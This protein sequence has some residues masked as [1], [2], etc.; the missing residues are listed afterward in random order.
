MKKT[1]YIIT[2]ALILTLAIALPLFLMLLTSE[3]EG[4]KNFEYLSNSLELSKEINDES[5]LNDDIHYISE[6]NNNQYNQNILSDNEGYSFNNANDSL[7]PIYNKG[8][9]SGVSY[10]KSGK[11]NTIQYEGGRFSKTNFSLD[12]TWNHHEAN[13]I[14]SLGLEICLRNDFNDEWGVYDE[15]LYI[16]DGKSEYKYDLHKYLGINYSDVSNG[17]F[18]RDTYISDEYLH[19]NSYDVDNNGNVILSSRNQSIIFSINI[20]NNGKLIDPTTLDESDYLEN[21]NWIFT[22]NPSIY[23]FSSIDE[24]GNYPLVKIDNSLED[25]EE[26]FS[27]WKHNDD[28]IPHF[29]DAWRN[30]I[31]GYNDYELGQL[32]FEDSKDTINFIENQNLVESMFGQHTVRVINNYLLN[33]GI[34]KPEDQSIYI[35]VHDNH[36]PGTEEGT[37]GNSYSSSIYGLHDEYLNQKFDLPEYTDEDKGNSYTKIFKIDPEKLSYDLLL[38][39]NNESLSQFDQYS[40]VCS[41]SIFFDKDGKHY[42]ATNSFNTAT[43]EIT[44][45]DSINFQEKTFVDPEVVIDSYIINNGQSDEYPPKYRM[46]PILDNI[47]DNPYGWNLMYL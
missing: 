5:L 47:N 8:I 40:T 12:A 34:F 2:A 46:Y 33:S 27:N 7:S 6:V 31:I 14:D 30:K 39:Y 3:E 24:N 18:A 20:L 28:Y 4:S 25:D 29:N 42:L 43:F 23:Y 44:R 1:Y 15:F 13:W 11:V 17:K 9:L 32:N 21:L 16:T 35:S 41:S 22:T 45:F 10:L 26:N 19:C 38:N 36:N 37:T